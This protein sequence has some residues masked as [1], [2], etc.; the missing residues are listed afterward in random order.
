[1]RRRRSDSACFRAGSASKRSWRL[2]CSRAGRTATSATA[3]YYDRETPTRDP[4]R[5][6][7]PPTARLLRPDRPRRPHLPS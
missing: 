5:L 7:L 1:M 6:R 2:A 3:G 4:E